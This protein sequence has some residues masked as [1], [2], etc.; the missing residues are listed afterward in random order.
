MSTHAINALKAYCSVKYCP[1][2]LFLD[3]ICSSTGLP[4]P[5]PTSLQQPSS[6]GGASLGA[7]REHGGHSCCAQSLES[8]AGCSGCYLLTPCTLG[9]VLI[10]R[11]LGDSCRCR[12][13]SAP[14][15]WGQA[16]C[17]SKISPRSWGLAGTCPRS[18]TAPGQASASQGN[19]EPD[20]FPVLALFGS[21]LLWGAMS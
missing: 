12:A 8:S 20:C 19:R 10:Y 15:T 11:G 4:L 3:Q 7:G 5:C 2:S 21:Q 13:F 9:W 16:P 1:V 18:R 6:P 17:C 14:C